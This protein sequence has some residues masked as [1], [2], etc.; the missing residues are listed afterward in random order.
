M[1]I[2]LML[3]LFAIFVFCLVCGAIL[4]YN[5]LSALFG[6]IGVVITFIAMTVA[7]IFLTYI[8]VE[9]IKGITK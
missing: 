1:F 5:L 8:L 6:M 3:C 4:L 9:M 7:V 2:F